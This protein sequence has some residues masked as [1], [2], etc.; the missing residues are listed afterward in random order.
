M[1]IIKQFKIPI[2]LFLIGI[3]ITIFGAWMKILHLHYADSFLTAGM[4]V[5]GIGVVASIYILLKQKK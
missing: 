1:E 5:K 3:L 4:L 2:F